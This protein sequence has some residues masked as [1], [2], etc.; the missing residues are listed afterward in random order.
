MTGTLVSDAL[1][2]AIFVG[3]DGKGIALREGGQIENF[4][5]VAIGAGQV[6]L[7]GPNGVEVVHTRL[8]PDA[9]KPPPVA[10]RIPILSTP[11][12]PVLKPWGVMARF[13]LPRKTPP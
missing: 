9:Y 12:S 5:I 13:P 10:V 6:I 7:V 1:R 8:S 11:T 4:L 3:T 2:V